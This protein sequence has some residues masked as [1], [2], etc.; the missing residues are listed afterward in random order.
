[1]P[2]SLV[3]EFAGATQA[4]YDAVMKELGLPLGDKGGDWPKG[5]ISHMAGSTDDGWCVIDVCLASFKGC[6]IPRS[7]TWSV[8][9]YRSSRHL[10]AP[11]RAQIWL[12]QSPTQ[13]G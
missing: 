4:Q 10:W 12:W 5:I 11:C 1:M 6:S 8:A 2:V 7:P 3:I 9:G 13:A